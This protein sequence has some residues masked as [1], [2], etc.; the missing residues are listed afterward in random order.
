MTE[1]PG[2]AVVV[3]GPGG[4]RSERLGQVGLSSLI[5][6]P[7]QAIEAEPASST[8]R[9]GNIPVSLPQIP[10]WKKV[11][12]LFLLFETK[13]PHDGCSFPKSPLTRRC[14]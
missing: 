14:D 3:W 9:R 2:F 8:L 7:I 10:F 1:G 4:G 12:F 13:D 11:G 5:S 6:T